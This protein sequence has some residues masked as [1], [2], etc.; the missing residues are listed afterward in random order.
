[1]EFLYKFL[2]CSLLP[3]CNN[4]YGT[5]RQILYFPDDSK[6]P[7]FAGRKVSVHNDLYSPRD[8]S[9]DAFHVN[10]FSYR[11]AYRACR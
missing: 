10:R 5:V 3:F 4:P 9:F 8:D 1:M 7:R 6:S 11:D 2:E